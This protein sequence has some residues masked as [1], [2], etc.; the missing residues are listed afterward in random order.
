MIGEKHMSKSKLG[1]GDRLALIDKYDAS[2]EQASVAFGVPVEEIETARD[3]RNSTGGANM[4]VSIDLN[5]YDNPFTEVSG[6]TSIRR[7]GTRK[8][9]ETATVVTPE[10]KKRGRKGTKI[11]AAFAAIGTEPVDAEEFAAKHNVSLNVLRQAKRF[12]KT[13][14][15]KVRV[16]KLDGRLRVFREEE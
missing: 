8:P 14:L 1:W 2:I 4:P 15:P 7:P 10:P 16:K 12:D 5:D 13:G 6:A 11:N 3:L 9:A